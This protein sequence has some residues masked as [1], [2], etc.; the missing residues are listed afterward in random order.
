MGPGSSVVGIVNG[1]YKGDP[2]RFELLAGPGDVVDEE[3]GHGA[4]FE[5]F[6]LHVA[7]AEYL[8]GVPVWQP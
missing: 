5:M 7:G 3:T 2:G 6:V 8:D 4:R 1:T